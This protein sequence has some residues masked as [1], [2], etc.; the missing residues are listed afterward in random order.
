MNGSI[1]AA[2]LKDPASPVWEN[3]ATMKQYKAI[4]A[5]Y[6]P[7]AN[8]NNGLYFYG[9]AK[10]QTFVPAMYKAGKNPTR[11][12]LMNALL[13]LNEMNPY[14]LP[15]V[16]LKTSA[17]RPLHHQPPAADAVQQRPLDAVRPAGRRTAARLANT[18][19]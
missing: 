1:S 4:M 2:Y 16:R 17:T 9:F 13:S 8:A 6:P 5:K 18:R 7:G 19:K 11:Q 14:T 3:D 15:G 12:G 10:A